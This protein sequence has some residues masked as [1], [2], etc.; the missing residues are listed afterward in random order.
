ME[1]AFCQIQRF[2]AWCLKCSSA[3]FNLPLGSRGS[4]YERARAVR[5]VV[6]GG[7]WRSVFTFQNIDH[8]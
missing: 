1:K 5:V 2:I 4:I 3:P 6:V 8:K 7:D